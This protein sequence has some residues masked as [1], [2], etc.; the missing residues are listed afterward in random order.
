MK[1]TIFIKMTFVKILLV[2]NI[3]I[4][5]EAF[6]ENSLAHQTLQPSVDN[7]SREFGKSRCIYVCDNG[8]CKGDKLGFAV[9]HGNGYIVSRSTGES[10]N[11]EKEWVLDPNG[12]IRVNQD[13]K[14]KTK[15]VERQISTPSGEQ[16]KVSER[17]FHIGAVSI[18]KKKGQKSKAFMR[19]QKNTQLSGFVQ[20]NK[21]SI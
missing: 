17:Y 18:L 19:P 8:A 14:Y 3:P 16:I 5:V 10:S 7:A 4:S 20:Y 1:K 12:Y 11:S 9:E 2:R 13:F 15:I 21:N 6:P